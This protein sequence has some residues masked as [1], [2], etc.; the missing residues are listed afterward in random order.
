MKTALLAATALIG[1]SLV[2]QAAIETSKY[3]GTFGMSL[4]GAYAWA[5]RDDAPDMGGGLLSLHN[6]IYS[7]SVISQV[8]LTTGFLGGSDT[9]HRATPTLQPLRVKEELRT[10]PLLAG[11]TLNVPVSDYIMFYV[12]AKAGVSFLDSKTSYSS[13]DSSYRHKTSGGKF[14]YAVGAGLKFSVGEHTDLKIGY[15]QYR[16]QYNGHSNPYHAVQAG[17]VWNF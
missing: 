3:D 7:G 17:I 4:E 12:D 16:M 1:T 11:Y 2:S 14:T 13:Q 15:E 6:Y 9:L 10:I 8:S 5:G